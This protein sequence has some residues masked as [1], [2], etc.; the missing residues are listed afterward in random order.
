M[1]D[2]TGLENV[3]PGDEAVLIGRS[4]EACIT[5]E[6]LGAW[7]NTISYEVLLAATER[8]HRRWI[9]DCDE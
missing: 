4:G 1:A 5:A 2:V 3:V 9:H 8:V 6:E 7:S